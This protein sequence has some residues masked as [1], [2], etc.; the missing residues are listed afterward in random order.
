MST[1]VVFDSGMLGPA[2][3][4]RAQDASGAGID[5]EAPAHDAEAA[6]GGGEIEAAMGRR[7]APARRSLDAFL[8]RE[9][10]RLELVVRPLLPVASTW[11]AGHGPGPV[12]DS[13]TEVRGR[14]QW[15]GNGALGIFRLGAYADGQA[16]HGTGDEH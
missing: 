5:A 4:R 9:Q 6:A 13:A 7:N 2:R 14:L 3:Q 10:L 16:Q 8:V 15:I 11:F 12:D 1:P